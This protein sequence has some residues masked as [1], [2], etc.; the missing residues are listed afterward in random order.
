MCNLLSIE[1][2]LYLNLLKIIVGF[3]SRESAFQTGLGAY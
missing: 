3:F 2:A 1:E